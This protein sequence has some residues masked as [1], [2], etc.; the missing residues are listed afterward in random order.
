MCSLSTVHAVPEKHTRSCRWRMRYRGCRISG[1]LRMIPTLGKASLHRYIDQGALDALNR[2]KRVSPH[3]QLAQVLSIIFP[4][5]MEGRESLMEAIFGID[6]G[7]TGNRQPMVPRIRVKPPRRKRPSSATNYGRRL[8][9]D[10]TFRKILATILSY[11][12]R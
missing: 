7:E 11:A 12:I 4:G 2:L 10:G 8:R 9:R 3:E 1:V 6:D 5:D